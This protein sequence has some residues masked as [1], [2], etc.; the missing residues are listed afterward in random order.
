MAIRKVKFKC[1][2]FSRAVSMWSVMLSCTIAR[3]EVKNSSFAQRSAHRD[4]RISGPAHTVESIGSGPDQH[5][6]AHATL[7][8]LC[9][10]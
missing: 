6:P 8:P 5:I 2:E 7:R 1:D 10:P 9:H 3:N 4:S